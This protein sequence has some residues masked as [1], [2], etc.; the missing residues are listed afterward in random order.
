M[1][2]HATL[3]QRWRQFRSAPPGERFQRF[4]RRQRT[5]RRGVFVRVAGTLLGVTLVL[6]GLVLMPAPGPGIPVVLAG[7]A[8]L[9][10]Q[11]L[12]A[13]RTLDRLELAVRRVLQRWRHRQRCR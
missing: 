1:P 11:S 6:L 2:P 3:R 4:H 13:A 7:A 10:A 5:A 9:A 8:L 12:L